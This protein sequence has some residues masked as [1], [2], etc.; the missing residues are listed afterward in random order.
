L[1]QPFHPVKPS[2]VKFTK[3]FC[4]ILGMLGEYIGRPV[5][6]IMS[7]NSELVEDFYSTIKDN[8]SAKHFGDLIRSYEK[9]INT[10]FHLRIQSYNGFYSRSLRSLINCLYVEKSKDFNAYTL[11]RD[12]IL[13][14]PQD[15]KLAYLKGVYYRFGSGNEISIANGYYKLVTVA[16]VMESIGIQEIKL[17]SSGPNYVPTVLILTFKDSEVLNDFLDYKDF[18]TRLDK[19]PNKKLIDYRNK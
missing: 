13:N 6:P 15:L 3:S 18:K 12:Y 16:Y 10:T 14:L 17:Y 1:A 5:D 7:R 9:E 2:E 19:Y 8:N 4:E 11:N